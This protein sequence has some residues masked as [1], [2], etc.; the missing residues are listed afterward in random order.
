MPKA[1][2]FILAVVVVLT[3]CKNEPASKA[4]SENKRRDLAA[5]HDNDTS[6]AIYAEPNAAQESGPKPGQTNNFMS[7]ERPSN[8]PD[9]PSEKPA[10][11]K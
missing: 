7:P 8:Q 11:Q 9:K 5:T 6:P 1:Y 10:R 4:I 2:A 3:G